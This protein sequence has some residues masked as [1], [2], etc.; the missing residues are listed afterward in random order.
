MPF[1]SRTLSRPQSV[2]AILVPGHGNTGVCTFRIS[3]SQLHR[4]FASRDVLFVSDFSSSS[5]N[6]YVYGSF[7]IKSHEA[8]QWI[9]ISISCV[10]ITDLKLTRRYEKR[11]DKDKGSAGGLLK[12]K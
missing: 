2:R 8:N 12:I 4:T 11:E 1:D 9:L 7:R 6:I 3:G 5:K 10:F